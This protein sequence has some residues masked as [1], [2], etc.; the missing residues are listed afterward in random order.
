LH[1]IGREILLDLLWVCYDGRI[2][3]VQRS[4]S[5]SGVQACDCFILHRPIFVRGSFF[6]DF[7]GWLAIG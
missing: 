6:L 1:K 5:I 7:E 2:Y 3:K 4:E